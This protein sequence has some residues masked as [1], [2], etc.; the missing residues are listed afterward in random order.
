MTVKIDRYVI[1]DNGVKE[2]RI[3]D[4]LK[5]E[6]IV[7][8]STGNKELNTVLAEVVLKQLN[9]MEIDKND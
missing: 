4:Y 1:F 9:E 8:L 3:Y 6:N 7:F 5:G 2:K